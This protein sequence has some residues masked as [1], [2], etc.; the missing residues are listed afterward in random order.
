L[1]LQ[2]TASWSSKH[3]FSCCLNNVKVYEEDENELILV[4]KEKINEDDKFIDISKYVQEAPN[5]NIVLVLDKNI[6]NKL[7]KQT[8]TIRLDNDE[9]EAIVE[10][11][12]AE[13]EIRI[14]K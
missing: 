13:F 10:Y 11:E 12:N 5:K 2:S 9:L 6:S 8:L 1:K 4:G 14:E 7:D 3:C